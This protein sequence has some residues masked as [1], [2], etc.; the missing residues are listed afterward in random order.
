MAYKFDF[1]RF[2]DINILTIVIMYKVRKISVCQDIY[3]NKNRCLFPYEQTSVLKMP[4]TDYQWENVQNR[5][6]A[7]NRSCP[8]Y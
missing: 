1:M 2:K 4:L 6:I 8:I 3:G 7:I 5:E